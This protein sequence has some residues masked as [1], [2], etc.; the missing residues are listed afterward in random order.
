MLWKLV[1]SLKSHFSPLNVF[2][3][4][5]FRTAYSMLTALFVSLL[6]GP[7]FIEKLK[8]LKVGQVIR[9]EGPETHYSKAGTP[10][11][12]GLFIIASILAALFIW[13]DLSNPYVLICIFS[14]LSFG[15]VGFLDDYLKIKKK[16]SKGIG[17]KRKFLLQVLFAFVIAVALVKAMGPKATVL[18]FPFFKRLT[19]DLGWLYIP[20]AVFVIVGCSNA[21]NLTDGLDGL[22]IVP[23]SMCAG[24]YALIAYLAGHSKF[25]KYLHIFYVPG[26]GEV[27]VVAAA[28]VGAGLGFLWFNAHP[29]EVFM[30]DTGSLSLGALLGTMA[31]ATKHELLL[32]IFGG[33]FV[34]ETLSVILQVAYF[35]ATGGKRIFKMA[36]FHHHVEKQGVPEPKIIVR[37]WIV[38]LIFVLIGLSTLKVR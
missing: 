6:I 20:F 15:F 19:P 26:A 32:P 25:A 10:T 36:P 4:V 2:H 37:F 16:D 8:K 5:T 9:R 1:Y 13:G 3:Y 22:A 11:M 35:K 12:G 23:V 7:W 33:I 24:A 14:L 21:V 18:Q 30:G 29:A 31:L 28:V 27:A 34:I 38:S 17:A